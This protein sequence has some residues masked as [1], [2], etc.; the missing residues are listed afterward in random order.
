LAFNTLPKTATH[1]QH[2]QVFN[3]LKFNLFWPWENRG[4]LLGKLLK[5]G[6]ALWT[7]LNVPRLISHSDLLSARF[8]D[9]FSPDQLTVAQR[10]HRKPMSATRMVNRATRITFL[11][12]PTGQTRPVSQIK[13]SV[14]FDR[15]PQREKVQAEVL[16]AQQKGK[17]ARI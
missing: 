5:A 3:I 12:K 15:L 9:R 17:C 1:S 8:P 11:T 4:K 13:R 6:E 10:Q 14:R 7:S 16:W 2:K